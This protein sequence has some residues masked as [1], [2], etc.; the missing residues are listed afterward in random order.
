[1]RLHLILGDITLRNLFVRTLDRYCKKFIRI[2]SKTPCLLLCTIFHMYIYGDEYYMYT[3]NYK[4]L[5][6][7]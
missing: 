2:Y 7:Q 6:I 1:M 3:K 4:I 5:Y